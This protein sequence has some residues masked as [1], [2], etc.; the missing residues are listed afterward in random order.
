MTQTAPAPIEVIPL[1]PT[2]IEALQ[3]SQIELLRLQLAA[4]QDYARRL[5]TRLARHER[6][7]Q[8]CAALG[9]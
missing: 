5:E 7:E 9:C 8:T 1:P 6:I 4:T 2:C 3:R